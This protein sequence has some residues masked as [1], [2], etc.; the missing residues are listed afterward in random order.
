MTLQSMLTKPARITYSS[1]GGK[2]QYG[3]PVYRETTVDTSCYYRLQTTVV[4]DA[5]YQT[6]EQIKVY[7]PPSTKA[8]GITAVQIDSTKYEPAGVPHIQWNP[9]TEQAQY[10]LL[11]VRKAKS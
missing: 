8:D 5:V 10:L 7:F 2:D 3:Q 4:G 9:R 11:S 1:P 6:E